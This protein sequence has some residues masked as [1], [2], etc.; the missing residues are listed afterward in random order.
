MT[1]LSVL[2]VD[3]EPLARRRLIR[4]AGAL[5]WVGRIAEAGDVAGAL[6]SLA[7]EPAD[8]LLL[9]VQ[10]P[11]GDGFDLLARLPAGIA[12][13]VVFVTAFDHHALRAFEAAAVDYVTK[14]VEPARL[15][16]AMERARAA[17]AARGHA[18]RV[19]ELQ[20]TVATLRRAV[21]A[22]ERRSRDLWVRVGADHVRLAAEAIL[23][24][25]AE[26]DYVRI[27]VRGADYLH[28]ESLAALGERLDPAEFLRIH[29]G[30]I[31]RRDAVARIR[32]GAYSALIAVLADGTELKVGRTY[33]AAV[34]AALSRPG[35]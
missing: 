25:Q 4:L 27:H 11:G 29:R 18:E 31:V 16:V 6:R 2:V 5:A 21:G 14:P 13:A 24:I 22:R 34:R 12:P 30:T 19:A 33:A 9:D 8:V 3:D 23:R 35:C 26:R 7:D 1:G 20:E 10:M 32:T 28:H 15:R 17:V